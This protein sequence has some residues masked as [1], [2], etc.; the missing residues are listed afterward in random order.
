MARLS[1][2]STD[3]GKVKQYVDGVF[4][5]LHVGEA[6]VTATDQL[7]DDWHGSFLCHPLTA[8]G[9]QPSRHICS[10]IYLVTI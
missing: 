5:D 10:V 4:D 2:M 8:T 1:R 3:L 6:A 7:V 9:R